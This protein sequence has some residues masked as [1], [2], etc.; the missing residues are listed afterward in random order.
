MMYY[1]ALTPEMTSFYDKKTKW[2]IGRTQEVPAVKGEPCGAGLHFGKT[3]NGCFSGASFPC[4]I[5]EAELL[6]EILGEDNNKVRVAKGRLKKEVRPAW[7]NKTNKF[8]IS[9]NKIPWYKNDGKPLKTWKVF[10]TRAAAWAAARAAAG[11][12]ARDA[13]R[14]AAGAAAWDAAWAAAWAAARAAAGAAAWAA[15]RDAARD[16]AGAA[17]WDAAW[18]AAWAAAR[19]AAGDAAGAAAGDAAGAA[20]G[21]AALMARVLICSGTKLDKKHIKH[22]QA[23][24]R[25]W[26]KGYG[27]LCDVNGVLFVYR[28]TQ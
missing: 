10:D 1:K 27:L 11:A 28:R 21:D 18:A 9:I 17:A 8:I 25:V 14:D 13:A 2:K 4:R 20:A 3:I 5:F 16:A 15:A 23:R 7:I 12:A 24:W 22:A 6:S 19:A 26:Q